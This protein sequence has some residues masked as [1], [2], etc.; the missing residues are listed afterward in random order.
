MN[1][2]NIPRAQG[3]PQ[4]SWMN[5]SA[6]CV[7]VPACAVLFP[8]QKKSLSKGGMDEI[9]QAST[10]QPAQSSDYNH[11]YATHIIPTIHHKMGTYTVRVVMVTL[12]PPWIQHFRHACTHLLIILLNA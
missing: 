5:S 2:H 6:T 3:F 11:P 7:E 9:Q 4:M 10:V 1:P 8:K 12:V